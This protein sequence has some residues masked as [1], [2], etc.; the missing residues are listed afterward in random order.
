MTT[1]KD[2]LTA[3][4]RDVHKVLYYVRTDITTRAVFQLMAAEGLEIPGSTDQAKW[5]ML[6]RLA[7]RGFPGAKQGAPKTV[8]R[9]G[10]TVTVRPW[11]WR[12]SPVSALEQWEA[13]SVPTPRG[14]ALLDLKARVDALE[15][16][17]AEL[18]SV[19]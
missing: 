1:P 10:K 4:G 6:G 18:E 14:Q 19:Q 3:L 7:E 17:V 16:R 9:W 13:G 5:R 8:T 11:C 15:A 2:T 12:Q